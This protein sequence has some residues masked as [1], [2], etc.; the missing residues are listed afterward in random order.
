M[1]EVLEEFISFVK[2]EGK[3]IVALDKLLKMSA[4]ED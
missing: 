2:Q 1:I 4:Y 3:E